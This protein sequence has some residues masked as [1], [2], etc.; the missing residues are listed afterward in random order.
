MEMANRGSITNSQNI[1]DFPR[2]ESLWDIMVPYVPLHSPVGSLLLVFQCLK[3]VSDPEGFWLDS[4]RVFGDANFFSDRRELIEKSEEYLFTGDH[5]DYFIS[6]PMSSEEINKYIIQDLLIDYI[7]THPFI[8]ELRNV[9]GEETRVFINPFVP[10]IVKIWP[11]MSKE[12]WRFV[13]HQPPVTKKDWSD[14]DNIIDFIQTIAFQTWLG[15]P[16]TSKPLE[17]FVTSPILVESKEAII[18]L[19]VLAH[20]LTSQFSALRKFFKNDSAYFSQQIGFIV[21]NLISGNNYS[22]SKN[23]YRFI[24]TEYP[25]AG[26]LVTA[27]ALESDKGRMIRKWIEHYRERYSDQKNFLLKNISVKS[28]TPSLISSVYP[29]KTKKKILRFVPDTKDNQNNKRPRRKFSFGGW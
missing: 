11:M 14:L 29:T 13:C 19:K 20:G 16:V 5:G 8:G 27:F 7:E 18:D 24:R 6:E 23:W 15:S 2:Y 12:G 17:D 9:S 22:Q 4:S 1:K 26:M 21:S 28:Y 3:K 10:E 25:E